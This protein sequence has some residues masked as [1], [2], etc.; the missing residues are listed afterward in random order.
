M[1]ACFVWFCLTALVAQGAPAE[2]AWG[3]PVNGISIGI[4][5]PTTGF[6][7]NEPID[8]I[9]LVK[10]DSAETLQVLGVPLRHRFEIIATGQDRAAVLQQPRPG[11]TGV[12]GGM[13]SVQTNQ[14]VAY[15]LNLRDFLVITQPNELVVTA[16]YGFK[17]ESGHHRGISGNAIIRLT[18]KDAAADAPKTE[19]PAEIQ[20]ALTA[21]Q[22]YYGG[23][24]P[25]SM[26]TVVSSATPTSPGETSSES[27][28]SFSSPKNRESDL[29][30]PLVT[31]AVPANALPV[32]NES[33]P[34]AKS[35]PLISVLAGSLL[36][37]LAILWRAARRKPQA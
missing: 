35:K 4:F 19:L 30:K 20:K 36:V 25:P 15:R 23:M 34:V 18:G 12:S 16:V 6:A 7:R 37:L 5:F 32:S 27:S 3:E 22:P 1:R 31:S 2:V 33:R 8:A 13:L 9:V 10:N 17:D 11:L 26:P 21:G 24:S 28:H 29:P 14:M